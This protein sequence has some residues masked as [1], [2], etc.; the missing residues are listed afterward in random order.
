MPHAAFWALLRTLHLINWLLVLLIK[1]YP[2]TLNQTALTADIAHKGLGLCGR[3]PIPDHIW[4]SHVP[5][6]LV[7]SLSNLSPRP[8]HTIR[9]PSSLTSILLNALA[10]DGFLLPLP[11]DSARPSWD[12]LSAFIRPKSSEKAAF[13]ADLRAANLLSP[14][15][16]PTFQL[17]SIRKI[18]DVVSN[19]PPGSLWATTIDLTN[20]FWSLRLPKKAWGA[21]RI[22]GYF[23]PC[24][25]FGWDLSP[26]LAQSSLGYFLDTAL[27]PFAALR[28]TAFWTFHYYDD[29]LVLATSPALT[30]TV[31]SAITT[32][33]QLLNLLISP[34]SHTTPSQ[35]VTWLGKII[36][37]THRT[38]ENTLGT[39]QRVMA[40]TILLGAIPLNPR[41]IDRICGFML[42]A[43]SPHPGATS[44][45]RSWYLTRWSARFL[46]RAHLNMS[47]A[48]ADLCILATS[49]WH[50]RDPLPD[51]WTCT[52]ICVDAAASPVG[53][54][55]GLYSPDWGGVE[56]SLH[57][58][59]LQISKTLNYMPSTRPPGSPFG[60]A[61]P[62]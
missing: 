42:W 21:F 17:P 10:R 46:P 30:S 12:N 15:P 14:N 4:D 20:F 11:A 52:T 62:P 50:A 36:D 33:L 8:P 16:K 38:V 3:C 2:E 28:D 54:Q 39:N 41:V 29:I 48:L 24:T 13:I 57:P 7:D 35:R 23:F 58:H 9:P 34:K 37:L 61:K 60:S 45:L 6:A 51:P 5:D 44:L 49:T 53:F 59:T 19:R 55:I 25:P 32:H 31:T 18:A 26:I 1:Y 27:A 47:R 40:L 43:A 56:S 22:S